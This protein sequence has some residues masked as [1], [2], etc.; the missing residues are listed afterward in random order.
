[1]MKGLHMP[2]HEG[3]NTIYRHESKSDTPKF[4]AL[5]DV[6]RALHYS[7]QTGNRP[8]CETF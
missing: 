2:V 6:S 5:A 1:M 7:E 8:S 3:F 4:V